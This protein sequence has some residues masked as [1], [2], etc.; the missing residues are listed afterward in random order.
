MDLRTLREYLRSSLWFAPAVGVVLA[1]VLAYVMLAADRA[2]EERDVL[3][4]FRAGPDSARIY[5]STIAA[6][7]ITFIAL[8]FTITIVVLQ[9]ASQQFS[10]R[11]LRTF[12]RDRP[13]KVAL[14]TFV[15]TFA[16]ALLVLREV[17]SGEGSPGGTFVP[18]LSVSVTLA[19]VLLSLGAFVAYVHHI[20]QAVRA[21]AILGTVG[22]ETRHLIDE[23]YP[24][25]AERAA[26]PFSP[27]GR[28]TI[29]IAS[30]GNPGVITDFD[31]EALVDLAES[32]DCVL[33]L[34]PAVGDFV[35]TGSVLFRVYGNAG[36]LEHEAVRKEIQL[37]RERTMQQDIAF[38][39]RQLADVAIRALSPAVNDPT[40]AV[41]ALDQIHD[42]LRR[43]GTRELR[44]GQERDA[45]GRIRLVYPSTSWEAYVQLGL[46]EIRRN[47]QRH[48]QVSRRIRALLED[49]LTAVR[50]DRRSPLLKE[51][52]ALEVGV[53][54]TF[55]QEHERALAA[56]PDAQG[57]GS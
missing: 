18:R 12:L 49:L 42:L 41:Q 56:K 4:A 25:K 9:L 45:G 43:L 16:F 26:V 28:L 10:P 55:D 32:S 35:P 33:E 14:A 27:Q 50:E 20:S 17:R 1:A 13:S 36:G 19:M 34:V 39:F 46:E 3:F 15:A 38:G 24:E 51:L 47:G 53:E 37:S 7:M 5:L 54:E 8:V 29:E 48:L 23:I 6:A 44:P 2:V 40:T 57:L 21:A 52:K 22:D 11:V 31:V 30:S